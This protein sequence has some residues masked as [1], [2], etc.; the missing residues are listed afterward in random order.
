[1]PSPLPRPAMV[2]TAKPG[3]EPCSGRAFIARKALIWRVGIEGPPDRVTSAAS[4]CRIHRVKIRCLN[5][6]SQYL[7]P[8]ANCFADKPE[9]Y[10]VLNQAA[11]CRRQ[12]AT[13]STTTAA[14]LPPSSMAN[15]PVSSRKANLCT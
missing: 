3:L 2:S 10:V 11:S 5:P 9:L 13:K 15:N 14:I 12:R 1:M 6:E 8:P 4:R 7:Y